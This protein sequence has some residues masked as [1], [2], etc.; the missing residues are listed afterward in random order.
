MRKLV[1]GF[2][3]GTLVLVASRSLDEEAPMFRLSLTSYKH[4]VTSKYYGGFLEVLFRE[5]LIVEQ[6]EIDDDFIFHLN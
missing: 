3:F 6:S 1:S 4:G 2:N 5:L